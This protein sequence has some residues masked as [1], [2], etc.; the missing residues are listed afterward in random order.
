MKKTNSIPTLLFITCLLLITGLGC[1]QFESLTKGDLEVP[2]TPSDTATDS[3]ATSEQTDL[4]T[5]IAGKYGATGTNENGGGNYIANL[6]V[7]KQDEVYQFSWN[8]QGNK[9]EGI[10]VQTDDRVAVSFTNGTD[11]TGCGVI[12]YKINPD[13]SLAGKSGY[14]GANNTETETATRTDGTGLEGIYDVDGTNLKGENY[15]MKL[16]VRKQNE[17][18]RFSWTGNNAWEGFGI[19]QGDTVSVGFGGSKCGF[20]AYKINSDGS[21]EGKWGGQGSTA[22]GTERAIKN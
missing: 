5:D 21:L 18:Y 20:V 7:T 9:Y 13:G 12:L 2:G 3:P 15:K 19:K 1:K 10:G 16:K 11:G 6:L 4:P 17:G 22:F 8:S 14:W